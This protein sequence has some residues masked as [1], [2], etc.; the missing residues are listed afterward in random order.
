MEGNWSSQISWLRCPQSEGPIQAGMERAGEQTPADP[1][2]K[3]ALCSALASRLWML[4]GI[5]SVMNF[6]LAEYCSSRG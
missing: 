5:H 3:R 6:T 2:K 1:D 4:P